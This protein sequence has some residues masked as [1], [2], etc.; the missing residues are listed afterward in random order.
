[1]QGVIEIPIW[2]AVIGGLAAG[3]AILDRVLAPSFRWYFRRRFERAVERLNRRLSLHIRP[4]VLMRRSFLIGRLTHDPEV[5]RAVEAHVRKTGMP[6]DIAFR[7]VE[8]YAKEITP[9][10]SAMVYFGLG[11]RVSRWITNWLYHVRFGALDR[12]ALA[13]IDPDAAVI[14]VIN[15]RSNVDYLLV[16]HLASDSV[17]I[18][19]AVG[20][21]ARV[22]PLSR[23]I[24]GMG[25]YFIRRR[26][27]DGLYRA[28]LRR[29]VQMAAEGGVTQAIFPEG[30]LSRDGALGPPK[31]GLLSYILE[32]FD[33]AGARDVVFVPVGLNYD[34]VLEDRILLGAEGEH[35]AG[36]FDIRPFR[37]FRF[38][39]AHALGRLTGATKRFGYASVGFGAPLSLRDWIAQ[40]APGVTPLGAELIRR[41]GA[42]TPVLPVALVAAALLDAKHPTP[43]AALEAR[44]RALA[45][46]VQGAGAHLHLPQDTIESAIESGLRALML[47]R[48]VIEAAGEIRPAP[49][50]TRLLEFYARSIA[51]LRP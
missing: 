20:E 51:H 43:R 11:A 15:H 39:A 49:D 14:F 41:I 3:V 25:A 10:F 19:Y 26:E 31:L 7:Q 8:E 38:L 33:P 12:R 9:S 44:A 30:G 2:L 35:G 42:V 1:M 28:V 16:T 4:F 17:T 40:H 46:T 22:W 24:R 32:G 34:R 18:S 23:V 21:W 37:A 5:M 6:R 47:R 48:L 50:E 29:Y 45:K 13:K 36:R 27:R